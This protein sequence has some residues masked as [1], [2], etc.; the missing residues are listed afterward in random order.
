MPNTW[1]N[2]REGRRSGELALLDR[3]VAAA[4]AEGTDDREDAP[5]QATETVAVRDPAEAFLEQAVDFLK[6]RTDRALILERLRD[7]T[8]APE[9]PPAEPPAAHE[10]AR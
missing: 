2:G 7:A 4:L 3:F 10:D 8:A 6:A 5:A 9:A 1:S